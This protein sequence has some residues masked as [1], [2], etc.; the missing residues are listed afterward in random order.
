MSET[1][2][3]APNPFDALHAMHH[4]TMRVLRELPLDLS[5]RQLATLLHIYMAQ[6]PH[7]VGSLSEQLTI[8]KPAICR[9]L[10]MLS[11]HDL[12]RRKKDE[13]DRRVVYLQRTVAGSV[14]LRDL[15]DIYA[16]EM[17]QKAA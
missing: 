10:D 13:E 16:Q 17:L 11:L 12:V 1:I 6:P 14:F 4:A 3:K 5:Q 8:S 15:G 2:T 9:A 7:T